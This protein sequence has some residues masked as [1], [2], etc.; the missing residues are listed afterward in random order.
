MDAGDQFG[1]HQEDLT[2]LYLKLIEEEYGELFDAILVKDEVET[3][4]ACLDL[5]WVIVGFMHAKGWNASDGW[6]EVA[7]SNM[8]KVN[9]ATGKMD[10]REDGKVIK[11]PSWSPPN[12]IPHMGEV[13]NG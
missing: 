6:Q 2:R 1:M 7:R 4:D 3:F 8:S 12:L 9:P 13:N 10:R 11:H 5:I